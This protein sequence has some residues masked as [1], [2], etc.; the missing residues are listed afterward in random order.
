[1]K[2]YINIIFETKILFRIILVYFY[3]LKNNFIT[4][5]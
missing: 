3:N 1:M 2:Y 4:I 5:L